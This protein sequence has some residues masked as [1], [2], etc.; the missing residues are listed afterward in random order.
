MKRKGR[1][2]SKKRPLQLTLPAVKSL[3]LGEKRN[4]RTGR[5]LKRR[6]GVGVGAMIEIRERK[7]TSSGTEVIQGLIGTR[8]TRKRIRRSGKEAGPDRR[9]GRRGEKGVETEDIAPQASPMTGGRTGMIT[10]ATRTSTRRARGLKE[11]TTGD[12]LLFS[13]NV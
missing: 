12:R 2:K 10:R 1:R 3:L 13:L 4:L 9:S 11:I 8:E 7:N 5:R 6:R